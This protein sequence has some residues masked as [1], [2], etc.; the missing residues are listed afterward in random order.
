MQFFKQ[1]IASLALM[2]A[3]ASPAFAEGQARSA[4]TE[5]TMLMTT[6]SGEVVQMNITDPA[7][8]DLMMKDAMPM[9]DHVMMMMH[10]GKMYMVHDK[11]MPDGKMLSDMMMT[12]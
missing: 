2:G 3:L 8:K 4:L 9:T 1:A 10:G 5:N 12:K 11:K 6:P 7:M